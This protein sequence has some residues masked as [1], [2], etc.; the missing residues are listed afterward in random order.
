VVSR[1]AICLLAFAAVTA[2]PTT[3]PALLQEFVLPGDRVLPEGITEGPDGTFFVGSAA[4]GTLYRIRPDRA[5]AE[6]WSPGGGDGRT[7]L[8]GLHVDPRG[9]L[10]ACGG[11]TGD[12]FVY[13]VASAALVARRRVPADEALLN[14]V[15]TDET[16][17]YVTDSA[18]PVLWRLPLAVDGTVGEPELLADLSSAGAAEDSFLN[19]IVADGDRRVLLVAAQG[20]GLLWRVD[21]E[22]GSAELVD[23][24]GIEFGADG[25]LLRGTG[26]GAQLIGVTNQGESLETITFALTMLRIDEDRRRAELIAEI[27]LPTQEYDAPTTLAADDDRVLVVCS[28]IIHPED[29]RPPFT[30]RTVELPDQ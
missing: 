8:L 13:D 7:E 26:D 12:L 22:T 3:T 1:A 23:C 21:L 11:A 10:V 16:A 14:D 17:A 15:V 6:V 24:G 25:L 29:P 28:Q 30:V 20:T 27:P 18:R 2:D 5:E 4:N 9:R 19:G